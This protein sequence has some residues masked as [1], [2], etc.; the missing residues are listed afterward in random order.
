MKFSVLIAVYKKDNPDFFKEALNSVID[1]TLKPDEIVLIEDGELT[2]IQYE[3]I[4][5]FVLNN[6][7][8][9]KIIKNE[10]NIGLGL[11]LQKGVK[12]SSNEI[13]A[14]MDSDDISDKTRFEKE[15]KYIE[16]G[17]DF[18]G[19]NT[20]EFTGVINNVISNR[21]M[22]ETND[23]IYEYIKSRNPFVH[24]SIMTKKSL[25]I[26]A[27]NYQDSYLC[28]DYDLW[29]RMIKLGIKCYN[30]QENLIYTRVDSNFY[31]RRKG[32]K[33]F[34]AIKKCL[35]KM[36]DDKFITALEYYKTIIPRFVVYLSPNFLRK[37]FYK[38]FLRS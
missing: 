15:I 7:G 24:A 26:E 14:R 27:G 5:D 18:V 35:K 21:I 23:K 3:I 8:L 36:K 10:I 31:K 16:E 13:I 9:F 22:P 11:S 12:E 30:I 17:Y 1:Q 32:Y 34:K 4:H 38:R 25:I 37:I 28:E 2:D 19:S 33:Y 29:Y 6:P 20:F